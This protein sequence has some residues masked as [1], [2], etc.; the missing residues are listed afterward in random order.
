VLGV[1]FAFA[2]LT[3]KPSASAMLAKPVS[4]VLEILFTIFLENLWQQDLVALPIS[5]D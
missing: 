3:A 2:G 4:K 1:G 5:A